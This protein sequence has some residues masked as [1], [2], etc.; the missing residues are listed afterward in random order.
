MCHNLYQFRICGQK[1]LA[2]TACSADTAVGEIRPGMKFFQTFSYRMCAGSHFFTNFAVA[3]PLGL[4]LCG[5]SRQ[6]MSSVPFVQA[7]HKFQIV[8]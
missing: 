8:L 6:E 2:A 1:R 7:F 3:K 4:Q 5:F